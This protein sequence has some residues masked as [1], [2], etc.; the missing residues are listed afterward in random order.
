MRYVPIACAGFC[1]AV[2]VAVIS[3][4]SGWLIWL[5]AVCVA[6]SVFLSAC[7]LWLGHKLDADE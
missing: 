1:L 3:T 6:A 7:A 2:L 5:A 4:G